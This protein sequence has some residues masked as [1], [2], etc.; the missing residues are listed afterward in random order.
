L[1]IK[2]KKETLRANA[3]RVTKEGV[4]LRLLKQPK[5][6]LFSVI[7]TL[8]EAKGKNPLLFS[9]IWMNSYG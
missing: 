8:S 9:I 4:I 7:L 6:P 2:G 5:N 1:I 3:L